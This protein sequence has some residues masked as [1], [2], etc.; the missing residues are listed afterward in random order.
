VPL[1]ELPWG[2]ELDKPIR[3]KGIKR[4]IGCS[5]VVQWLFTEKLI[6]WNY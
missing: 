2:Y 1:S 5:D 6:Y 4:N 3:K